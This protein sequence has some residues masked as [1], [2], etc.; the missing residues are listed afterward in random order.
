MRSERLYINAN[1]GLNMGGNYL[2]YVYFEALAGGMR[3]F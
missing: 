2:T 1:K 3:H